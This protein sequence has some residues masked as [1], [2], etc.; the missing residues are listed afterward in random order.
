MMMI[1]DGFCDSHW[2]GGGVMLDQ[3][4]NDVLWPCLVKNSK[5]LLHNTLPWTPLDSS[6]RTTTILLLNFLFLNKFFN[7]FNS[8]YANIK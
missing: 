1:R 7:K 4:L 5:N 6:P 2:V 3:P 8:T